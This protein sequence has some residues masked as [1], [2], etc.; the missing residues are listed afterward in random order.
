[1]ETFKFNSDYFNN[2]KFSR[3][4]DYKEGFLFLITWKSAFEKKFF[5]QVRNFNFH[6]RFQR[7]SERPSPVI[8]LSVI[9]FL[10]FK[11]KIP[12][13]AS[14]GLVYRI[15]QLELEAILLFVD[16]FFDLMFWRFVPEKHFHVSKIVFRMNTCCI[17][18]TQINPLKF[19]QF[20][21]RLDILSYINSIIFGQYVSHL[22][23]RF[24]LS[25]NDDL[26]RI[27]F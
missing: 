14:A 9:Y 21:S 4:Q 25:K 27:N 22:S 2:N 8:E 24:F 13:K 17:R 12:W 18:M 3:S 16:E 7:S 15:R 1:M 5:F 23:L 26:M 6:K 20:Y 10:N 19:L 11:N